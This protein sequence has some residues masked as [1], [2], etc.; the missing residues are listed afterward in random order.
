MTRRLRDPHGFTLVEVLVVMSVALVL[1][2]AT[3]TTFGRTVANSTL[4]DKRNDA[5]ELARRALD[6]EARQLRNL[7]QRISTNP[8]ID[9]VQPYDFIFQTSDP[10]KTWV[11]YCLQKTREGKSGRLW[12][13]TLQ[14][15]T[16]TASSSVSLTAKAS[17]PGPSSSWTRQEVVARHIVNGKDSRDRPLF[18]YSCGGGGS[19]C[20][21]S[22]ATYDQI[23]D[24]G[25]QLFVDTTPDRKPAELRVSTSVYLRNQNQAPVSSFSIKPAGPHAFIF[26]GSASNDY[27]GRTLAMYWFKTTLPT[28]IQCD[29]PT[30]SIDSAGRTRLWG[31]VLIGQGITLN[32]TFAQ[33]EWGTAQT[34][35]LVVCDPG[36][37]Y[38]PLNADNTKQVIP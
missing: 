34:I 8:I 4:N 31:G 18:S 11:R 27:E 30:T 26:N 29:K 24:V 15:P 37:R 32:H 1:F 6:R 28:A 9:R 38:A 13:S 12:E 2:G 5:A 36:H 16:G 21:A 23:V 3:L 35:Q 25:A 20:T 33:P 19:A 22:P 14:V 17:C 10:N 7:A